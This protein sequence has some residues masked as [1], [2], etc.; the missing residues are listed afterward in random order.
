MKTL[1][2]AGFTV[3]QSHFL[4]IGGCLTIGLWLLFILVWVTQRRS[5]AKAVRE[6]CQHDASVVELPHGS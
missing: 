3:G 2:D 5:V 1:L 4:L 6:A